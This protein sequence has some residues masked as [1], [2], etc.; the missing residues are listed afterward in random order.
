MAWVLRAMA[1]S[2][3]TAP[4]WGSTSAAEYDQPDM[5]MGEVRTGGGGRGRTG[6]GLWGG[7]W[8]GLGVARIGTDKCSGGGDWREEAGLGGRDEAFAALSSYRH[9]GRPDYLWY[10]QGPLPPPACL[11]ACTK[12]KS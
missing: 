5:S 1:V 12:S 10:T 2:E 6:G 7:L 9:S 11:R 3:L 8:G 4:H